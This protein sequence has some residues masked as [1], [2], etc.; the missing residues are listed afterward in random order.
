MVSQNAIP[1][2]KH[3]GGSVHF[4]FTEQGAASLSSLCIKEK[5]SQSETPF[6]NFLNIGFGR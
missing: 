5:V 4:A 2:K 6:T 1:S 3:L